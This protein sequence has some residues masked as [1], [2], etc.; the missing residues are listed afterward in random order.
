[1]THESFKVYDDT[2]IQTS[3]GG[4][5][6]FQH[7]PAT[8]V[9]PDRPFAEAANRAIRLSIEVLLLSILPLVGIV[10]ALDIVKPLVATAAV[11]FMAI[12]LVDLLVQRQLFLR[13]MRMTRTEFKRE[14]RDL[15]GDPLIRS[16]R[17]RTAA[18]SRAAISAS[19][20][21]TPSLPSCMK[22][23]SSACATGRRRYR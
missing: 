3:Q 8:F 13:D 19:A 15:E 9:L 21:G 6:S 7:K 1:M 17:R 2:R 16:E 5:A 14:M 11:M 20:S 4:V 23:R 18:R 10:L 22:T 12:G